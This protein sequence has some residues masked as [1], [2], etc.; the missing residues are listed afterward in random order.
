MTEVITTQ[1][2]FKVKELIE[3]LNSIDGFIYATEVNDIGGH[4]KILISTK[5]IIEMREI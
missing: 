4:R 2:V 5:Y 1:R 3:E